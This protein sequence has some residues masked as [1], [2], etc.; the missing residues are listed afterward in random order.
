MKAG[1]RTSPC[2][3]WMTPAR[4]DPSREV[5]SK[6]GA[7]GEEPTRGH[8]PRS[9][10]A[11][12]PGGPAL[13]RGRLVGRPHVLRCGG[14][15]PLGGPTCC[16]SSR[17][18]G[19]FRPRG[20]RELLA[21]G[22][23]SLDGRGGAAPVVLARRDLHAARL[24]LLGLGDPHLEDAAVELGRDRLGVDAVRQCQRPAEAAVGALDA[25]PAALARLLLGLALAGDRER[26]V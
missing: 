22:R 11:A 10:G 23:A 25:V 2:A 13:R 8:R 6:T 15:A 19:A 21:L 14:A 20:R 17:A 26:A 12:P 7:T 9:G 24:A 16:R 18:G 4:A 1:V 5:I 3:V